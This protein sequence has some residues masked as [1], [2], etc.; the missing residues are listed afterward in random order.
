[1]DIFN[2]FFFFPLEIYFVAVKLNKIQEVEK[3]VGPFFVVKPER[4]NLIL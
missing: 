2:V 1:M 3:Y 4:C